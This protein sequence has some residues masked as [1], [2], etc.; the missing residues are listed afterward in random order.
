[1]LCSFRRF[2]DVGERIK[3]GNTQGCLAYEAGNSAN[4]HDSGGIC[5][6]GGVVA[7]GFRRIPELAGVTC[8]CL[9]T[10]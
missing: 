6:A 9:T 10:K 5:V 4:H 1:M 8:N 7:L 3:N 2:L